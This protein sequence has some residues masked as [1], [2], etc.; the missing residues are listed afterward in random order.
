LLMLGI[1]VVAD[2]E[3]EFWPRKIVEVA[4]IV[5]QYLDI[6]IDVDV[7]EGEEF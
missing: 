6:D 3:K 7:D 4:E 5:K 2:G 1:N